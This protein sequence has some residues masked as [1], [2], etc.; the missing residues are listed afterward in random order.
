MDES[1]SVRILGKMY[2]PVCVYCASG[3]KRNLVF[4]NGLYICLRC[5]IKPRSSL[6][7]KKAYRYRNEDEIDAVIGIKKYIVNRSM[8]ITKIMHLSNY[9]KNFKYVRI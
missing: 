2:H 5:L 8:R 9:M 6:K 3:R 7:E 1:E 4:K